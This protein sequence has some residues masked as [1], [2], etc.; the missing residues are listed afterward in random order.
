VLAQ[1]ELRPSL[2]ATRNRSVT[3]PQALALHESRPA[4]V[5]LRWWSIHEA[6]W[7]NVTLFD[8]AQPRLRLVGVRPLEPGDQALAEAVDSLGMPA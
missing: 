6:L 1:H 3:Q 8:R 5:G 4:A 2:V 7:T